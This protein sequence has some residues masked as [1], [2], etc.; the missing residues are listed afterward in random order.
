MVPGER[1]WCGNRR[2]CRSQFLHEFGP[3]KRDLASE[4][5]I[6]SPPSTTSTFLCSDFLLLQLGRLILVSC[7]W[8]Y[9]LGALGQHHPSLQFI[10]PRWKRAV[11]GYSE[12]QCTFKSFEFDINFC[13]RRLAASK[14]SNDNTLVRSCS[15][16]I[17]KF[18]H[19]YMN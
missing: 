8:W 15:P 18:T 9:I 14:F 6:L 5:H 11:R 10:W 19:M 16:Q 17:R 13:N 1:R 3:S 2:S 12:R 7:P 4:W